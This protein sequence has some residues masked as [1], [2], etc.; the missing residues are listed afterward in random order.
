MLSSQSLVLLW[1]AYVGVAIS[2]SHLKMSNL[3]GKFS[4]SKADRNEKVEYIN[5]IKNIATIRAGSP[6]STGVIWHH[7]GVMRN[8]ITGAEVVGIEGIEFTS[9]LPFYVKVSNISNSS[10]GS[11]TP[12]TT[13]T[14][15][16][17]KRNQ[18]KSSKG[19]AVQGTVIE[20]EQF[21]QSFLS[22][23]L[24]VYVDAK[25]RSKAIESHRIHPIHSPARAVRPVKELNQI[26]TLGVDQNCTL[27]SELQFPGGRTVRSS[28]IKINKVASGSNSAIHHCLDRMGI[29]LPSN[30][31]LEIIHFISA[32]KK[33][34][35][36]RWIS[37]QSPASDIN[38]RSQEYYTMELC[39]GP[40]SARMAYR[41]YGECPSWYSVGKA[42]SV[43]L[44]ADRYDSLDEVPKDVLHRFMGYDQATASQGTQNNKGVSSPSAGVEPPTLP[45]RDFLSHIAAVQA[46]PRRK[47]FQSWAGKSLMVKYFTQKKDLLDNYKPWHSKLRKGRE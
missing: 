20:K 19:V 44:T 1:M 23:K 3:L 15:L 4:L 35:F 18:R 46:N 42:S 12:T 22:H 11:I 29:C 41:R 24:F 40:S 27:S 13:D 39:R 34:S 43:E 28:R 5:M 25:N 14:K 21:S 7:S 26:V 37:F 17:P 45:V 16:S 6:Q 38:G 2:N 30:P 8:P 9:N 31:S 33:K 36:N 32:H 10:I 47:F